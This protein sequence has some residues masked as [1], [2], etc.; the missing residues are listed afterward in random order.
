MGGDEFC[1][2]ASVR[3]DLDDLT[4]RCA[5]ALTAQGDGFS[6]TAAHGAVVLPDEG[7][8]ASAVLA[9]AD[10]RMYRQ[11]NGGRP[12]AAHQSAGVLMA[13][14]AERAPGLASHVNAVCGSHARRPRSWTC[15][16]PSWRRCAMR[17]RSTTSARWRSPIRSSRS[18][19]AVG[20][21]MGADPPAHPDRRAHPR[22]PP[23]PSSAAA[24]SSAPVTS[25]STGPATP[26]GSPPRT[27]R[28]ARASSSSPTRSTPWSRRAATAPR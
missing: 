26:T 25:G 1:V 7:T 8:D 3:P 21:R 10:A 16:A 5:A 23:P 6:I 24:G 2:L 9:L 15:T 4:A 12:P 28:W 13:V 11:K 18:R 20:G 14:V 19:G 27:S 22:R 17:L